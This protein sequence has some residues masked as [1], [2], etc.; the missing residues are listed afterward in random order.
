MG[1][2]VLELNQK[3]FDA[4]LKKYIND[5]KYVIGEMLNNTKTV[6][7]TNHGHFKH[8]N[9][10]LETLKT[11]NKKAN[12]KF[13]LSHEN[14]NILLADI[15]WIHKKNIYQWLINT[16]KQDKNY[17]KT[18][19]T[20]QEPIPVGV[21][22]K[23]NDDIL[24]I[25]NSITISLI[26]NEH[27]PPGFKIKTYYPNILV[28]NE[29]LNETYGGVDINAVINEYRL[30]PQDIEQTLGIPNLSF[31]QGELFIVKTN[32][33]LEYLSETQTIDYLIETNKT[34]TKQINE[35]VRSKTH[36][37]DLHL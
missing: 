27:N 20:G 29:I 19:I 13:I 11:Q 35:F 18:G 15:L 25:T 22:W 24:Y 7:T 10:S 34:T 12:S 33:F 4:Q 36:Y 16:N 23:Q 9:I 6:E 3:E 26:R 37:E 32:E 2:D 28:E 21:G 8:E 14:V 5:Y 1:F 30:T 31:K 17:I